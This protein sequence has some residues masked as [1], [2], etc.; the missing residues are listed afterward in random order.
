VRVNP[1]AL[2]FTPIRPNSSLSL[3][4]HQDFLDALQRPV[5]VVFGD[6]QRRGEL[7]HAEHFWH[8][9]QR[10]ATVSDCQR[11]NAKA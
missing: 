7:G 1:H 10:T 4:H 6:G 9:N 3:G 5:D 8:I 2:L 11:L